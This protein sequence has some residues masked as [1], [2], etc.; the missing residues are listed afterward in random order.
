M[1]NRFPQRLRGRPL[2]YIIVGGWNTVFGVLFFTLLYL[3][4][5]TSL[6]YVLVLAIAQF[7]AVLQ[8]HLTQRLLVWRSRASYVPELLRFSVIYAVG[9][10]VNVALLALCLHAFHS[11][12][13]PTQWCIAAI[14][15]A[16]MYLLQRAWAFRAVPPVGHEQRHVV[17]EHHQAE[18]APT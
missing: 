7:V 10:L 8:A 14:L 11:P 9:Y 6:G 13:L 17:S 16:P 1:T 5:G 12:V 4:V 15:L 2:R 3:A 18:N